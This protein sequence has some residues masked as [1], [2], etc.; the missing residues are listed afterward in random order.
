MALNDDGQKSF[1]AQPN[2]P[3]TYAY[4]VTAQPV[5]VLNPSSVPAGVEA[6]IDITGVN[7]NFA[8]GQT[9]VG[10]GSSDVYVR[11]VFVLSPTHLQADI[12]VPAAAA[13]TF[14]EVSV[15]TGFQSAVQPYAFQIT[16]NNPRLPVASPML[17]NTV[18]GQTAIYAGA[19]VSAFGTNLQQGGVLPVVTFNGVPAAV[20]FASS[21][22][23]EPADPAEALPQGPATMVVSNGAATSLPVDVNIVSAPTLITGE[24]NSSGNAITSATPARAGRHRNLPGFELRRPGSG[25]K[26]HRALPQLAHATG[27]PL[28]SSSWRLTP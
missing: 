17:V 11:Q 26:R 9:T 15:F 2:S 6:M 23:I 18:A 14:T 28:L 8:Q 4:P 5:V 21:T 20:L 25:S 19:S 12:F 1:F 24:L 3:A 7:T 13:Q 10:F 16:A 22:Q 27:P